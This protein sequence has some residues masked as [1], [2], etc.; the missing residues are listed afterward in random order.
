MLK[1]GPK[2]SNK[3]KLTKALTYFFY[4]Y[5]FAVSIYFVV[6]QL[7]VHL[8]QYKLSDGSSQRTAAINEF[9]SLLALLILFCSFKQ[10]EVTEEE[11]QLKMLNFKRALEKKI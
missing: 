10:N 7:A 4:V 8:G 5:A 2:L 11:I 1:Q 3:Q 6:V 9:V